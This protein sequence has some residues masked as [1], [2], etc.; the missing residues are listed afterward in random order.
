MPARRHGR[1]G[2]LWLKQGAGVRRRKI[3]KKIGKI[4]KREKGERKKNKFDLLR[5][6]VD[7]AFVL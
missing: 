1:L 3:N 6:A 7:M 5:F 4:W 2:T